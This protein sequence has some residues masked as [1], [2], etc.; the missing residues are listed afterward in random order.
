M[1]LVHINYNAI[2]IISLF[3]EIDDFFE[4]KIIDGSMPLLLFPEFYA[5]LR[6]HFTFNSRHYIL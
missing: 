1:G 3:Y 5:E 6:N 4:K 2:N